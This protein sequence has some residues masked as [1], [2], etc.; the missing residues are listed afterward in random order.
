MPVLPG[1]IFADSLN[2]T[3][4]PENFLWKVI[5]NSQQ[6]CFLFIVKDPVLRTVGII[7]LCNRDRLKTSA[8]PEYISPDP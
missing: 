3:R 2:G 5:R 6:L 1:G 7:F 4:N 8:A